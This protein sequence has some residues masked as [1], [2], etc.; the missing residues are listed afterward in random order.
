M[1]GIGTN[2]GLNGTNMVTYNFELSRFATSI[3]SY[4]HKNLNFVAHNAWSY[5]LYTLNVP[6]HAIK[7]DNLKLIQF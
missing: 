5:T 4:V 7:N 2:E 6:Q 1:Y 3:T